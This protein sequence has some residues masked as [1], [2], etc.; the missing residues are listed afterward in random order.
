MTDVDITNPHSQLHAT[1]S[2]QWVEIQ[3]NTFKNWVNEQLKA[4][5]LVVEDLRT[6]FRDGVLLVA[7]LEAVQRRKIPGLIAT[8]T[9][10]HEKL[11]NIT[12]A[13][14][15]IS[16]DNVNLVNIGKSPSTMFLI[17]ADYNYESLMS[18]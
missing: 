10:H 18:F 4:N 16:R 15:A 11:Q 5:G 2:I 13:L 7:L 6:D 8:P 12:V 3:K 17:F 1:S 9:N 14:D